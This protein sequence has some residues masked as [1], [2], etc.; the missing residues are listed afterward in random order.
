MQKIRENCY[1]HESWR[2]MSAT[3]DQC[4]LGETGSCPCTQDCEW[5]IDRA[6]VRALIYESLVKKKED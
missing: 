3:F 2:D 5:F 1:W 6:H 4:Y